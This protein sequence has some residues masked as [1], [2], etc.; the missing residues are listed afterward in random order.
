MPKN[1]CVPH[2]KK[3]TYVEEGRKISYFKFPKGN[4]LFDEWIRAIRRDVGRHFT[5]NDNTRVC[6]RHF[7]DTDFKVSRTGIRS[8]C[9]RAVPSIFHWKTASLKKRKSPVKSRNIVQDS[10]STDSDVNTAGA[11][12]SKDVDTDSVTEPAHEETNAHEIELGNLK[13]KSNI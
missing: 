11:S 13:T 3:K 12:T 1:C 6:S 9:D 4:N 10:D 2:C 7:K 5:V 8:L